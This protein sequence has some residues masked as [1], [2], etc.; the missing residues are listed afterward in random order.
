MCLKFVDFMSHR[1]VA[2]ELEYFENNSVN[3]F[4]LNQSFQVLEVD[5]KKWRIAHSINAYKNEDL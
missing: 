5:T 2:S 3:S 4:G 1:N